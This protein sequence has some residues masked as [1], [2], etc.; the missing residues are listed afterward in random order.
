MFE[1]LLILMKVVIWNLR[2]ITAQKSFLLWIFSVNVTTAN[3]VTFAEEILNGK[4]NF[5]AVNHLSPPLHIT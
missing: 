4:L 2:G 3:L 1:I 5:C